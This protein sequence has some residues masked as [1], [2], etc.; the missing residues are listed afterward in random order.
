MTLLLFQ[1]K[2]PDIAV[3]F[4]RTNIAS[5]LL[6]YSAKQSQAQPEKPK[7]KKISAT[8]NQFPKKRLKK[9]QEIDHKECELTGFW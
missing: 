6:Q 3:L 1:Q 4:H 2:R 7:K 9:R 5:S 8:D